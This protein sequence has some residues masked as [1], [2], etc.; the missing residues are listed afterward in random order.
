MDTASHGHHC[1]FSAT[2]LL[3]MF[4]CE[5]TFLSVIFLY[6]LH[7]SSFSLSQDLL[8]NIPMVKRNLDDKILLK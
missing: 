1:H 6:F 2:S 7:Y 5:H 3:L 4:N 8:G